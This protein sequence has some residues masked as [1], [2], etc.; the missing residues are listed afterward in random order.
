M[1]RG[2]IFCLL[3]LTLLALAAENVRPFL[4]T[5]PWYPADARQLQKM[6]DGFFAAAPAPA[7]TGTV[8]GIIAPHAGFAYSGQCAARA[9]RTLQR[10]EGVHRV[11]LLG[12]SHH[13]GFYGACVSDHSAYATPLGTVPVDTGICLALAAKKLFR[14]DR[15]VMTAEHSLENQLPFLQST[16]AKGSFK[17][18]PVIFG[19]LEIKDYPAM[20]AAIAPYIDARTLVVASSDL[21]HYGK[22]FA[23]TPFRE[24]V[25]E[26]LT[27]LDMGF[28]RTIENLA[29][30]DYHRYH[31]KTGIS[32]CGIV[33]IG[34]MI[35]LLENRR[36]DCVLADYRKSG[37]LN[38]DYTTSVSYAALI[39]SEKDMPASD[40]IGLTAP[41]QDTLLQLARASLVTYLETEQRPQPEAE[42]FS[43]FARLRENLGVFVTLRKKGELRGCIG[44]LVGR[45][46]LY[47][48]VAANAVNA[49]VD[50]PRFPPLQKK[51][52]AEVTIEISVMTPLRPVR[53]HRSIRLGRDGVVIVDGGAQAVFLPQ[54]A[55]ETGWDLD[56]FL[57]N[58]CLKAGLAPDAYRH[59]RT[60][61]FLVFQA[62]VFSEKERQP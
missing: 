39:C 1:K 55:V 25:R 19:A 48:G 20:A 16:L 6:L 30:E 23:Y 12:S 2:I 17:I 7:K 61:Q 62:Q 10:V 51:E 56:R 60:M 11:I 59:S 28:I 44:S 8:R 47:R 33:P 15:T 24:D 31:Q 46:P 3:L 21:T 34:I 18:V 37:D 14:S 57:A 49:A 53:D 52:L 29:F 58:L 54:V 22:T 32:A 9:Y 45:E 43:G 41:E 40:P 35:K 26:R 38:N 13:S 36:L 50:D 42:R 5:G 4:Q 27:A